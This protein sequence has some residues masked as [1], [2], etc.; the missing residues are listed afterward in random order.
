MQLK[1]SLSLIH[2]TCLDSPSLGD[3]PTLDARCLPFSS[4]PSALSSASAS[5]SA[6][7]SIAFRFSFRDHGSDHAI[8]GFGAGQAMLCLCLLLLAL[9]VVGDHVEPVKGRDRHH[10]SPPITADAFTAVVRV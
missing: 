1:S 10:R 3:K 2:V 7:L 8:H 4:H 5:A 9:V 6:V